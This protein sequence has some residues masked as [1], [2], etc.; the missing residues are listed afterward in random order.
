VAARASPQA[1]GSL[2]VL[3]P[4]GALFSANS[5]VTLSYDGRFGEDF[6]E[7]A[8]GAKASFKF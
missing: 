6:E 7:N 2:V 4:P 5:A 8:V 3:A 1:A